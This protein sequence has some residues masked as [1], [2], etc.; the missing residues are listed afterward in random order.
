MSDQT[1]GLQF[2]TAGAPVSAETPCS[3]CKLPISGAYF[4][5][6][7]RIA[8][9]RCKSEVEVALRRGAGFGSYL[10]AILLGSLAGLVGAA[11]WYGVRAVTGYEL[12]LIAVGVGYFVGA[13]VKKAS[14]GLGGGMFQ[15]LAVALTYFWISANYIPDVAAGLSEPAAEDAGASEAEADGGGVS[16]DLPAPIL[17]ASVVITALALPFLMGTE[18]VIGILIIGFALYEAW[19]INKRVAI[20]VAGPFALG[21]AAHPAAG[22]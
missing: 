18:N 20:A 12:G 11:L 9:E 3:A 1:T 7:N 16:R 19:K 8:C 10:R 13:A 14:G 22:G 15:A 21:S 17:V 5:V 6:G 2:D 4:T